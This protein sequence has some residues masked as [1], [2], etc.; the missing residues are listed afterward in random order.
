[1]LV[2]WQLRRVFIKEAEAEAQKA[3][4]IVSSWSKRWKL[5]MNSTKSEA[6]VFTFNR[7]EAKAKAYTKIDGKRSRTT[8]LP[9]FLDCTLIVS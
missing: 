6:C 4:D 5:M 8:L 9:S 1:M 2:F 3:V 7:K